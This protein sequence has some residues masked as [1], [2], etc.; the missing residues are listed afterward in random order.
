MCLSLCVSVCV[1]RGLCVSQSV[2]LSLCVSVCVCR[3]LCVS[4]SVCVEVC[5]CRGLSVSVSQ[6][7][8]LGRISRSVEE[9]KVPLLRTKVSLLCVLQCHSGLQGAPGDQQEK[10]HFLHSHIVC[11]KNWS[12][13]KVQR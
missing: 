6:G 13:K 12:L 8:R 3:G 1:C 11:K 5:V 10:S 4:R 7:D 2:C 9:P